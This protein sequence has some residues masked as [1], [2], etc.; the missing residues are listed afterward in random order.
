MTAGP[1]V[2]ARVVLAAGLAAAAAGCTGG[3]GGSGPG[4]GATA[5][6]AVDARNEAVLDAVGRRLEQR[7]DLTSL[8][9]SWGRSLGVAPGAVVRA[10]CDGCDEQALADT[11]ARLVWLSEVDPLESLNV[12]VVDVSDGGT[13]V[14]GGYV[15][16]DGERLVELYGERPVP[17]DG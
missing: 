17:T 3:T 16:D 6:E 8:D 2:L 14:A 13:A 4:D 9:L 10:S 12:E 5:D 1:G 11:A 7:R 15:S